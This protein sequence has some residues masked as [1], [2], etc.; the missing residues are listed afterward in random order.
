M[1]EFL[2]DYEH[3]LEHFADGEEIPGEEFYQWQRKL[4]FALLAVSKDD[5]DSVVHR[6]MLSSA[7]ALLW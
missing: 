3:W 2:R 1:D 6:L 4:L 5:F 7:S